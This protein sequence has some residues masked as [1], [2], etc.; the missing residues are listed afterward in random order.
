MWCYVLALHNEFFL[1]RFSMQLNVEL[2]FIR[3]YVNVFFVFL[4]IL[5][6]IDQYNE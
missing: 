5:L 2:R 1:V 6:A 3:Q 4:H